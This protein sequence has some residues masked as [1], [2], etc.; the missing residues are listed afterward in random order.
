MS[1][2]FI[3]LNCDVGCEKAI[4]DELSTISG[5]SYAY[6]TRGAY[7]III[8]LELSSW[9]ELRNT[10]VNIRKIDAVHATLTLTVTK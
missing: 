8:K 6:K 1:T 4:I 10:I 2:A 5:M 7:D 9:N 3:L